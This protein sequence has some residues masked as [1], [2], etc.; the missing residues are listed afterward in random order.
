M[1]SNAK[2][3]DL[4]LDCES[5]VLWSDLRLPVKYRKQ[6]LK[7]Q[8]TLLGAPQPEIDAVDHLDGIALDVAWRECNGVDGLLTEEDVNCVMQHVHFATPAQSVS[9]V[10][11]V[12]THTTSCRLLLISLVCPPNSF[13]QRMSTLTRLA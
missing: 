4:L 8:R 11:V 2:E 3:A 9:F 6:L 1:Q 13:R 5:P 7:S 12:S 10:C